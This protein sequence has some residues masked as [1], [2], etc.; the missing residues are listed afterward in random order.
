MNQTRRRQEALR[1]AAELASFV[2]ALNASYPYPPD[3]HH[4]ALERA[5]LKVLALLS[6]PKVVRKKPG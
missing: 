6:P 1:A 2:V 4:R 3:V 5:A